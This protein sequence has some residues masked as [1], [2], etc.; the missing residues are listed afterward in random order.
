[1]ATYLGLGVGRLS[2][3]QNALCRWEVSKTQVRNLFSRQG[4]AM[5]WDFAEN[6]VF[7]G[8]AGDYATSLEK[9]HKGDGIRA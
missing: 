7:N 5:I 2:D 6:N 1:M 4:M 3:I 8:A 9:S